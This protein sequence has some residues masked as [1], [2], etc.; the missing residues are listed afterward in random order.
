MRPALDF[1]CANVAEASFDE[2]SPHA[3]ID[4]S[5]LGALEDDGAKRAGRSCDDR[6]VA[7]DPLERGLES[8]QANGGADALETGL[9]PYAPANARCAREPATVVRADSPQ[10]LLAAVGR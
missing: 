10:D 9:E 5:G 7:V 8:Q 1:L 4:V 6:S 3:V 2:S